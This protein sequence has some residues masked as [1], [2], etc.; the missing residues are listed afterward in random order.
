MIYAI[1]QISNRDLQLLYTYRILRHPSAL[2]NSIYR[3]DS[4]EMYAIEKPEAVTIENTDY[5]S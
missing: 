3:Y 4:P 2:L 1:S 5:L